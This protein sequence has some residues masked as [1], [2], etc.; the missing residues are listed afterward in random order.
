[1]KPN[2]PDIP[3]SPWSTAR[4]QCWSQLDVINRINGI[5]QLCLSVPV[6]AVIPLA[7]TLRPS[8]LVTPLEP[9][10]E[11]H[12]RGLCRAIDNA[13]LTKVKW[14]KIDSAAMWLIRGVTDNNVFIDIA[15][16]LPASKPTEFEL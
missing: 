8:I 2:P 10:N 14:V 12:I 5:C 1:M 4:E 11:S 9:Q 3:T 6:A 7:S 15:T 16:T 13:I